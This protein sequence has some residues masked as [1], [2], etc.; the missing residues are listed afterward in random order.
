MRKSLILIMLFPSWAFADLTAT[1]GLAIDLSSAGA[2]LDMT[3]ALDPT[4]LTG[5][6]TWGD[7][8]TDTIVWTWNRATGTD[9]TMTMNSGSIGFQAI[10]T[11]AATPLLLTNGQ[12]VN[13]ALTS[14]TVGPTTLTI[15]DF[16][17]VS[18]TFA[19]L[20]LAQTLSNKTF[21]APAL[22]TPASGTLTNCTGL[23]I[24][25]GVSGLGANVATWLGTPSSANL[26]AALTDETGSGAAVFGTTPTFSTSV[27][28][29]LDTQIYN[30]DGRSGIMTLEGQSAGTAVGLEIF[31]SD[32]DG[33]DNVT[34]NIYGVGDPADISNRERLKIQ[35]NASINEFELCVDSLG[36]GTDR[37]L[38]LFA[39]GASN[40]QLE[41]HTDGTVSMSSLTASE[42]VITDAS[43]KLVSAAVATYPSLT[44][45][46]YVKGV[47]SAIQTQIDTKGAIAGQV[48]TGAHDFGGAT[49][50]ELVNDAA[51]T[52]NATGE[53]ALD[54]T[55]TDHQPL[56]QYYDGGENMTV[57]AIDTA[58]LPA[59]DNEIIKYDAGTD[60]FVLEADAGGGGA[61]EIN[62]ELQAQQAKLPTTK[63]ALIDGGD[64]NWRLLFDADA[65]EFATWEF[66]VDD[67][68]GGGTLYADIYFTM[69][70]AVANE[71]V[72]DV[73]IM[74]VTP[75][76][77]QDVG[78][79]S[80]D[81]INTV[82]E[83]V[84]GT[85]GY[86]DKSTVTL[87]NKDSLAAGDYVRLRLKR[88]AGKAADDATGD[89]EFLRMVVRE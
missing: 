39:G 85:A 46:T 71:V 11:S 23:P 35:Y 30:W 73:N 19:F 28:F 9:P 68:Y 57:I 63:F 38:S 15:P 13:I 86:L 25:T 2:G 61:S 69:V 66:I 7:G 3:I 22:G 70:S 29:D 77:A 10:A 51:P 83:T 65:N 75:G 50:V 26:A 37:A 84:P 14:Q 67:D 33:T 82:T 78:T 27:I 24:S 54:T 76:D 53:I 42:I 62:V 21:V 44:E 16:A 81:T 1:E 74:A 5:S 40:G 32:G 18:D 59:L 4:E 72:W 41:L 56:W 89:A 60:K 80:Y 55:I 43:K 88:G 52:T 8:S 6:R 48:W 17:S 64:N 87:T 36:T 20:T 31:P 47:T 12:L 34:V 79:D 45:L 58:E 49:S